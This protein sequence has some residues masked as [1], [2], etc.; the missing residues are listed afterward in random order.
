[1]SI[2]PLTVFFS[3][4]LAG[5]FVVLFLREQ[6]RSHLTSPERDSLLPL[7]DEFPQTAG[8]ALVPADEHDHTDDTC[9]CRSGQRHPCAHC[10]RRRDEQEPA[11]F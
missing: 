6:C 11:F 2:I 4:L 10:L 8:G 7:A 9:T 5:T 3:L 1:M